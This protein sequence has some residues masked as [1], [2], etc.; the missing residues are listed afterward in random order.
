MSDL[1][2]CR[3]NFFGNSARNFRRS[4]VRTLSWPHSDGILAGLLCR[5][6]SRKGIRSGTETSV[7]LMSFS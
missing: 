2:E 7:L 6:L 4:R 5:F 1:F 3:P